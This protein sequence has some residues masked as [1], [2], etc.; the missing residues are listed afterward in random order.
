M[1]EKRSKRLIFLFVVLS[2]I[3]T[4]RLAPSAYGI[5]Q[6][7]WSSLSQF[8]L[9]LAPSVNAGETAEV[10][11]S[12][13]ILV[14]GT[15]VS[16]MPP[17][18]FILSDQFSGFIDPDSLSSIVLAEMPA[19]AYADLA[20]IFAASPEVVTEAFASQGIVLEVE[21][22]SSVSV[23]ESQVPLVQG[24][25]FVNGM[26]VKK[27]FTILPA[28]GTLLLTFNVIDSERLSR[29]AIAET[30]RSVAIAPTPSIQE[31]V[32]EL[33]FTFQTAAPFQIL[34]VFAGSSVLLNPGGK[35]D[36]SEEDPVIIIASSVSSVQ[37]AD[38]AA[39]SSQIL[40]ATRGFAEVNITE[41]S[42]VDFA[43]REGY[44]TQGTLQEI[45][46]LQ[47]LSVLPDGF[48]IRLIALGASEDLAELMPAIQAI[49]SSVEPAR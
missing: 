9:V 45:S 16:L 26:R 6:E 8:N 39:L 37:V 33:P 17:P 4:A 38:L 18:G 40:R 1:K 3:A 21:S 10:A 34:D 2:A 42:P 13:P 20:D 12:E 28:D 41:Q 44:L 35:P 5:E 22:I 19:A 15:S 11:Q 23:G 30:I 27:Y 25:Q 36:P 46:V 7:R 14:P 31:K 29:E 32:A 47:Y 48:Y 43:G 49:Q 24:T